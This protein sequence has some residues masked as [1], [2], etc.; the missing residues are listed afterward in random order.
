MM[1]RH[2]LK[3]CRVDGGSCMGLEHVPEK[4]E[5]FSDQN[6]LQCFDVERVLIPNSN[7]NLG[8]ALQALPRRFGTVFFRSLFNRT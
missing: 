7:P 3:L 2:Y 1:R 6:M 4:C 8:N 5:R